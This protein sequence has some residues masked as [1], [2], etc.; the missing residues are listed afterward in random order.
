MKKILSALIIGFIVWL[1]IKSFLSPD[2]PWGNIYLQ[3][4]EGEFMGLGEESYHFNSEDDCYI[5]YENYDSEKGRF[6]YKFSDGTSPKR[7]QL[8]DIEYYPI[9]RV[10]SAVCDFTKNG[11]DYLNVYYDQYT[12]ENLENF[13][14][15]NGYQL[16]PN[17]YKESLPYDLSNG[18]KLTI[19]A[20]S[21]NSSDSVPTYL[22]ISFDKLAHPQNESL[23]ETDS[24]R[25]NNEIN[26][27]EI[28][29][30]KFYSESGV[31]SISLYILN[32]N[33]SLT[34][35]KT[36]LEYERKG[37]KVSEELIFS[38]AFGEA[39]LNEPYNEKDLK[40]VY[41][42]KFNKDFSK[43]DNG[44]LVIHSMKYEPWTLKYG[45]DWFYSKYDNYPTKSADIF[46]DDFTDDH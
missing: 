17:S 3:N 24:I 44:K 28:S 21:T 26:T 39:V 42:F 18:A 38:K 27:Y 25:L 9:P 32:K 35:E 41:K 5:S 16:D 20:R 22:I 4:F 37:E 29:I 40:W 15:E 30:P 14:R 36:V 46:G 33:T 11:K 2:F 7:L 10:L 6:Y 31:G 12:Y 19:K 34:I 8:T 13:S 43:I 45:S 1:P 23:Y